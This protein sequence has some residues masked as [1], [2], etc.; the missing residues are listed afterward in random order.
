MITNQNSLSATAV[1]QG[2]DGA[3][4]VPDKQW[5]VAIVN[6]NS[7]VKSAEKLVGLGY[8]S[9]AASQRERR[10]WRNGR[11]AMVDR[12]V[13]PS[14]VFIRCTEAERRHI[15]TL[16]FI[17]RFLTNKAAAASA[18]GKPV[19]VIPDRQIANLRFMLG[20]SDE[21]VEFVDHTYCVGDKVRVARGRLMGLEGMVQTVGQGAT[22]LIVLLDFLGGATVQINTVDIEPLP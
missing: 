5:Y 3:V 8:D 15:V 22:R 12:V 11:R 7:E 9:F 20:N 14:M 16:P 10:M 6:H 1:P 18:F 17:F 21:P 13:I 19:A 2:V 4:G